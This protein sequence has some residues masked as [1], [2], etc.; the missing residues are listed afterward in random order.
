MRRRTRWWP[1]TL[2][3]G[4]WELSDLRENIFGIPNVITV[5]SNDGTVICQGGNPI[6]PTPTLTASPEEL[7]ITFNKNS[8]LDQ[9]TLPSP[10]DPNSG[11]LV[12]Y[13][14]DD[15]NFYDQSSGYNSKDSIN[16]N[17][18][19]NQVIT[20]GYVG[21]SPSNPDEVILRFASDLANGNYEVILVGQE[22]YTAANQ[23]AVSPL[24]NTA[25][26]PFADQPGTRPGE[27]LVLNFTVNLPPQVV[28][29]D[30]QPIVS[31]TQFTVSGQPTGTLA[32]LPLPS[33]APASVP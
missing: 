14:G 17:V 16:S 28:S 19:D 9:G 10:T 4:A 26:L 21:F 24:Q 5:Q 30:P 29:V 18:D 15:G 8:S 13:A 7:D 33:P 2:G 25:G 6:S 12:V 3:R 23:K 11:I 22:G 32:S 31:Q 1:P 27:N 20:P